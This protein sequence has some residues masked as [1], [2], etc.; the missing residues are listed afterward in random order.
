MEKNGWKIIT[1][2]SPAKHSTAIPYTHSVMNK[3]NR[4][5]ADVSMQVSEISIVTLNYY[6]M[7]KTCIIS[8]FN[9]VSLKHPCRLERIRCTTREL[10]YI[11]KDLCGTGSILS[12]LYP[13]APMLTNANFHA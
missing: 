7:G 2:N 3:F 12:N 13:M 9:Q 5:R 10:D 4:Q 11:G 6:H 8:E 1:A